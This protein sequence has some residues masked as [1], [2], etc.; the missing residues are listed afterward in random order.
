M[1][2]TIDQ[3]QTDKLNRIFEKSW[4]LV[5]TAAREGLPNTFLE[6]AAN[7]CAILSSVDPDGLAS[8]FGYCAR[9]DG[10]LANGLTLLLTDGRWKSLGELGCQFVKSVF[11][12]EPAIERHLEAY[13][14]ALSAR[15]R[16][17]TPL[18]G[19][20]LERT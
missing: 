18:A 8:R 16:P 19:V 17:N 2:G 10:D 12:I 20:G 11:S 13:G 6:A 5:N 15:L 7:R 9:D 3:F 1:T 4:V 14:Q